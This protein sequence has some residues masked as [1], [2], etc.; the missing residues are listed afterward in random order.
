MPILPLEPYVFPTGLMDDAQSASELGAR[1]WALHT[2][3]R[4]E[5]ALARRLLRSEVGFFLPLYEKR[6]I[7]RGR[8]HCSHL[9]LFPGYLFLWGDGDAR[10]ASLAT[11]LVAQVLPVPDQARLTQDLERVQHLMASEQPLAPMPKLQTGQ[12]VTVARGPLAGV[13]GCILDCSRP[14][15]MLVEVHF[16]QRGVAVELE[17]WMLEP[18]TLRSPE[19]FAQAS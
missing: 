16:L 11:N 19:P 3:P 13:D 1:W 15:R 2:K 4:A 7:Q 9:P 14:W 17:D 12:M 6:W 5:K 18:A 8:R 10:L